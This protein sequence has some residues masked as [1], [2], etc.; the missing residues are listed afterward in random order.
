MTHPHL[1]YS[2]TIRRAIRYYFETDRNAR[3]IR[4]LKASLGIQMLSEAEALSINSF[5]SQGKYYMSKTTDQ[6][7]LAP[8]VLFY[9][10]HNLIT[11][12]LHSK[13]GRMTVFLINI[14]KH[15][16]FISVMHTN[17]FKGAGNFGFYFS[18][19]YKNNSWIIGN[20]FKFISKIAYCGEHKVHIVFIK[21]IIFKL[22]ER[23]I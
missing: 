6:I 7:I 23:S 18:I 1:N 21:V 15:Q 5:I 2:S 14:G 11:Y 8:L 17:I 3:M 10:F 9:Y 13:L 16:V 12:L 20:L 4:K 22:S 19:S